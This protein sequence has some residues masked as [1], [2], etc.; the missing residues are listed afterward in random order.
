M[1]IMRAVE[2][3]EPGSPEVLR[4]A[5]RPVPAVGAEEV[6]IEVAAAGLNG[7]DLA[8]RRG[9]YPPPAGAS[10]IPGL[11]VS[12]TIA[13]LGSE[14]SGFA[15][16][17]R[18]CALL[19]GG[20]YAEFCVV[21]ASQVLKLPDTISFEV[22]AGIMEAAT[23]VWANVF[24]LARLKAGETLLVHG[25]TSGI[26]TTAIQLAKA[27]EARVVV[28][29]G[30]DEKA[31]FCRSLGA[32]AAVN[33]RTENF[34]EVI[35]NTYRGADVVLDIVGGDYLEQNIASMAPGGRLVFIAFNQGRFG[36]LDIARVMMRGLT[37]TGSTLRSRPL[38]EKKR[39][40]AEMHKF[41][42][43]LLENGSFK[44]V[45][46]KVFK[47]DDVVEAHKRMEASTH[48]GKIILST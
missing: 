48:T 8:Q 34:A 26:G 4:L 17:D 42:W 6:L 29:C 41:V 3:T 21:A 27:M 7:A 32:D 22:G 5:Q 14:V 36:N 46:D 11:E 28:T 15:V 12:G 20:G 31:N 47:L 9:V 44:P 19:A 33:Y 43:P 2:I 39:L 45:I 10:D 37:V 18:V 16:G 24:E 23:T 25:G 40:V 35:K 1:T 13:A 38:G 30:S